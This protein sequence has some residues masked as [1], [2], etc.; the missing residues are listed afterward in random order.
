[1][2]RERGGEAAENR[3]RP[4]RLTSNCS[5]HVPMSQSLG[6]PFKNHSARGLGFS[7]PATP[8]PKVHLC[9]LATHP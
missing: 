3:S 4:V 1:M 8:G 9:E 5:P 2:S 6:G 7:L